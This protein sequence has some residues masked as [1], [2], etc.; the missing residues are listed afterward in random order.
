MIVSDAIEI[1]PQDLDLSPQDSTFV[2]E[3]HS[4]RLEHQ[5]DVIVINPVVDLQLQDSTSAIPNALEHPKAMPNVIVIKP[6]TYMQ[7]LGNVPFES[8]GQKHSEVVLQ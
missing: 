7:A 5:G 2:A 1:S 6:T 8:C 4:P 3:Q